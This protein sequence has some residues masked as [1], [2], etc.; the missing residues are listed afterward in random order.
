MYKNDTSFPYLSLCTK[1]NSKWTKDFIN[2]RLLKHLEKKSGENT[3]GGKC[4]SMCL[5]ILPM[6]K[7][8]SKRVQGQGTITACSMALFKPETGMCA[9]AEHCVRT[10]LS[11]RAALAEGSQ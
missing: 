3:A 7:A 1:I 11:K 6:S 5:C 8:L 9:E 2:V 4:T 10:D